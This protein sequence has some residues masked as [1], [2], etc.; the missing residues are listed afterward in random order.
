MNDTFML[1]CNKFEKLMDEEKEEILD[2]IEQVKL[3]GDYSFDNLKSEF[4]SSDHDEPK[5]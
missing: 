1:R 3:G 4:S 2:T 5:I